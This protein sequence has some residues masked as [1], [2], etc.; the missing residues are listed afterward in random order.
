VIFLKPWCRPDDV[1][2]GHA[3]WHLLTAAV[4]VI[5]FFHLRTEIGARS[6][7]DVRDV[8]LGATPE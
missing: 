5:L 8:V 1:V 6:R 3:I 4:T 2:Q 7:D